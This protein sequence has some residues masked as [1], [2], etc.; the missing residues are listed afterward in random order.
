M[1]LNKIETIIKKT[2]R[3]CKVAEITLLSV[4][5]YR[6]YK[7]LIPYIEE[8]WWLRSPGSYSYYATSIDSHGAVYEGGSYVDYAFIGVRPVLNISISNSSEFFKGD[9]IEIFNKTWTVLDVKEDQIY[10]LADKIIAQRRFDK[11]SNDWEKSELK[12]WL[13]E[14]LKEQQKEYDKDGIEEEEVAEY[15]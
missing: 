15:E 8:D 2:E 11:E 12:T 5:E 10:I 13:E 7:S 9:S 3:E 14:W 6:C 1:K 4:E